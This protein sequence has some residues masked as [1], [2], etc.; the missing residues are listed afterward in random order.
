MFPEARGKKK[1][2]RQQA[3]MFVILTAL[4]AAKA[5]AIFTAKSILIPLALKSITLL[6]L[7]ALM[8][9]KIAVVVASAFGFLRLISSGSE[10]TTEV[11]Y[12]H[13]HAQEHKRVDASA[14]GLPYIPPGYMVRKKEPG[15][16]RKVVVQQQYVPQTQPQPQHVLR[17]EILR[18]PMTAHQSDDRI[19]RR[20]RR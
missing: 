1:K 12:D 19:G 16:K 9:G 13:S 15:S 20:R 4:I 7:K 3:M 6:A 17:Q 8:I 11:I 5:A 18:I 10:H 14:P 2:Q